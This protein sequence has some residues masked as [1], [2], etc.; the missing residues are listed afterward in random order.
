MPAGNHMFPHRSGLVALSPG[1]ESGCRSG[2]LGCVDCK[3]MLSKA[4][5]DY[6][7]EFRARRERL[8]SNLDEVYAL[9]EDGDRRARESAAETMTR[10]REAMGF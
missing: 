10:A 7:G 4:L 6:F 9:L 2:E 5:E 3:R 8:A 1:V